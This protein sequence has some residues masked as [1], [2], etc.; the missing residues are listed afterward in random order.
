MIPGGRAMDVDAPTLRNAWRM[1]K[2]RVGAGAEVSAMVAIVALLAAVAY[3]VRVNAGG[4]SY[5]AWTFGVRYLHQ[6]YGG[7]VGAPLAPIGS[8]RPLYGLIANAFIAALGLHSVLYFVVGEALLGVMALSAYA[9]LRALG[10]RPVNAAPI[11]L[12]GWLFPF[13]DSVHMI[14]TWSIDSVGVTFY[15]FGATAA[16]WG[17]RTSRWRAALLHGIAVLLYVSSVLTYEIALVPILMS[18]LLYRTAVPWSRALRIGL[19]DIAAVGPLVFVIMSA[20]STSV[21]QAYPLLSLDGSL[22]HGIEI[23]A[24][25][26][27]LLGLAIFPPGA[28]VVTRTTVAVCGSLAF[29]AAAT[30]AAASIRLA[31]QGRN[32]V[33]LT[34]WLRIA[35]AALM[36]LVVSYA[37]FVP[38]VTYYHP[39]GHGDVNR[40]NI[41][42][43]FC[44]AAWVCAIANVW[45]V[46][47]SSALRLPQARTTIALALTTVVGALYVV[48]D[49]ADAS[50]WTSAIKRQQAI[51]AAVHRAFPRLPRGS[52]VLLEGEEAEN[53]VSPGIYAFFLSGGDFGSA[54]EVSYRELSLRADRVSDSAAARQYLRGSPGPVFLMNL[55]DD[56]GRRLAP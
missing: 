3:G 40:M 44:F 48:G 30:L 13:A 46:V 8:H 5:D 45:G 24:Q 33:E 12:L 34:Q 49:R 39:L 54:L 26:V 25:A 6:L 11:A 52:T 31:W 53:K 22:H 14:A 36:S 7:S 47:I 4:F 17:L 2:M 50:R 9:F 42:A 43:A 28:A 20:T 27:A 21:S 10:L 32:T 15:F 18:A 16:L 29:L 35:V 19:I 55:H 51:L 23:A 1:R 38:N 37:I 41:L 56:T